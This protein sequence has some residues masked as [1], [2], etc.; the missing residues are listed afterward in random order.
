MPSARVI[1]QEKHLQAIQQERNAALAI[2]DATDEDKI[3]IHYDTTTRRRISGEWTSIIVR[4]A[5][6]NLFRMRPLTLALEN[7][8]NISRLIVEVIKRLSL[9][10]CGHAS[11]ED[12]WQKVFAFMTDSVAKNL[13]IESQIAATLNSNHIPLHLLCVSHTCEVFDAGNISILSKHEVKLGLREK[14]ISHMP[15]LKSFLKK[16]IVLAALGALTKLSINDGHKSSMW[17]LFEKQVAEA[18]KTKKHS[19]FRE[20]RF[21]QM[22]YTAAAILYHIPEYEATLHN[23]KSNNLLLQACRLY[24]ECDFI[25]IGLKVLAWFTYCVTLPF[26]NMTQLSTQNDL[27]KVLPHLHDDLQNN[28]TD[29]LSSY[30]VPY[31]FEVEKPE[32]P[33]EVYL[34]QCM[35]QQAAKDLATQRGREYGFQR[36]AESAGNAEPRATELHKLSPEDLCN[37][38]TNNLECERDLSKFD[39]LAKRSAATSNRNFTAKGIRDD[40]TL[41]KAGVVT[42]E[43]VT[44][45]IAKVLDEN[46]L[47][48]VEKQNILSQEKLQRNVAQAQQAVEYV[49]TLLQKCK[50]W[51]GPFT[52]VGEMK[53]CI[54]TQNASKLKA[55]L[56]TELSYRRHTSHRDYLVRPHLYKILSAPLVL[57]PIHSQKKIQSS[58]C[59]DSKQKK[60]RRIL[61]VMQQENSDI[62]L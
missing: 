42:V 30:I 39:K 2:L 44:R 47:K 61:P 6:G 19:L 53:E 34:L 43:K 32:T 31:S 33:V 55:I 16:S 8:E 37:L 4:L 3:T 5:S 50:V 18:G 20:R 1:A 56:R 24:L 23:T 46:E 54:G 29:T 51:G 25:I 38:P 28:L 59:E 40:M 11:Q 58:S 48:W 60:R 45:D 21:A 10:T 12:L 15:P 52:N 9:A 22:G 57:C 14:L 49:H 41:N 27:V 62:I 36:T 13:Q 17:E 7:R 26:L 35:C